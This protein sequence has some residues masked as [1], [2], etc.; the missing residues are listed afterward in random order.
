ML[1]LLTAEALPASQLTPVAFDVPEVSLI[2]CAPGKE[3]YQ[4]EGHSALRIKRPGSYDVAVNWG[5]FDFN[6]PNFVYR[7]VKGETDYIGVSY[8]FSLLSLIHI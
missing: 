4:L 3:I 1:T 6:A 2:T 7:F 8:P 5:V